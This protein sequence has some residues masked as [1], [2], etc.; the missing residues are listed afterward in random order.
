MNG[1]DSVLLA[2][3]YVTRKN[4]PAVERQVVFEMEDNAADVPAETKS[5]LLRQ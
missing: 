4:A 5:Q 1:Y 3:L 2:Y